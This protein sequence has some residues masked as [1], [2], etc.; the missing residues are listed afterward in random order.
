GTVV[1]LWLIAAALVATALMFVLV[2]WS[3]T[4]GSF[5][6]SDHTLQLRIPIYGRSI[7]IANLDLARARV[8]DADDA[9]AIR[10][11]R[12]TNGIGMPGYA[13]GWFKLASGSKA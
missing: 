5:T 10:D 8:L 11:S 12:R 2:A 13:A 6:V 9:V 1:S 7:P 3:A 4:H